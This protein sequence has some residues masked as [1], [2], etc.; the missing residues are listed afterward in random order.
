M[1][2]PR[3]AKECQRLAIPA[4]SN[5]GPDKPP[6]A[7]AAPAKKQH[8]SNVREFQMTD[9]RAIA[10]LRD[11]VTFAVPHKDEPDTVTVVGLRNARAVPIR[12]NYVTFLQW[13]VR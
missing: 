8:A 10:L 9:G 6:A 7:S 4:A 13:W 2:D 12:V 1:H 3:P 5:G 11:A